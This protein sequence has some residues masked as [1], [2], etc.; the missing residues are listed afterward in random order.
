VATFLP[1]ISDGKALG[2][3]DAFSADN[4]SAF[5]SAVN[6]AITFSSLLKN[7]DSLQL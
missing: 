4:G 6:A 1:T 7:T 2:S 3:L 5:D